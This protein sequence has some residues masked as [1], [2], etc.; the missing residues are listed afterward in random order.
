[1][2]VETENAWE[3]LA[4]VV[5]QFTEVPLLAERQVGDSDDLDAYESATPRLARSLSSPRLSHSHLFP[6]QCFGLGSLVT[7]GAVTVTLL[8]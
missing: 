3:R 1:M 2:Q 8:A 4:A 7:Q 5:S 6:S